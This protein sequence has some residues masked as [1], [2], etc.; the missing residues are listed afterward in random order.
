MLRRQ[1][2]WHQ[3]AGPGA[4]GDPPASGL[5]AL[6]ELAGK[7]AGVRKHVSATAYELLGGAPIAQSATGTATGAGSLTLDPAGLGADEAVWVVYKLAGFPDDGTVYPLAIDIDKDFPCFVA[8]S[9]YLR[10]TWDISRLVSSSLSLGGQANLLSPAPGPPDP[11]G[12]NR[13]FYVAVLIG[14][15]TLTVQATSLRITCSAELPGAPSADLTVLSTKSA[16]GWPVKF[17]AHL[18]NGGDGT[19]TEITY[20]FGDGSPTETK[21]DPAEIVPHT[22]YSVGTKAVTLTVTNDQAR[23]DADTKN[24]V[25]ANT[26]KEV[27]VVYNANITESEDLAMYYAS[28]ETGRGIDRQYILGL[29]LLKGP[30]DYVENIDRTTEYEPQIRDVIKAWLDDDMNAAFTA[31]IKYILLCKGVPHKIRGENEFDYNNSTCS[32]VDSELC[33]LYSDWLPSSR[34]RCGTRKSSRLPATAQ[35][36][37]L[38]HGGKRELHPQDVLRQRQREATTYKLDYLVGRLTGY[39][40]ADAKASV[41]RALVADTSGTGWIIFDSQADHLQYDTMLEPVWPDD[42]PNP[43]PIWQCGATMLT[44]AGYNVVSDAT[45]TNIYHDYAALQPDRFQNVIGYCSWGVH[46]G[47]P[48]TYILNDL[49]F[50]YRPGAV[51]MSYES[52]N[53]TTFSC[54]NIDD[55]T[56]DHA[57]QGQIM[58]F[59]HMGGTVAIGNAWEPFTV[60]VGDERWVFD[61]YIAHG[62]R[63]IEAAYKGLRLLSWQEVVVGDPLCRVKE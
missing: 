23:S 38:L 29:A 58:D 30:A 26:E 13:A 27:L 56:I 3:R 14:Q 47:N 5:P 50:T 18:S 41:D 7:P 55:L 36:P 52:F 1:L 54:T 31:N 61:R 49:G 53:A 11:P 34:A 59:I 46:N 57:G 60:G 6:S 17:D 9:N 22:Y 42:I 32:S 25:V 12:H 48:T 62:D 44:D 4:P 43:D 35:Q 63:W 15:G 16:F 21:S 39:S 20:D 8:V 19:I 40:Y 51:F 24:V 28:P 45:P 33:T 2:R 10:G 37:E